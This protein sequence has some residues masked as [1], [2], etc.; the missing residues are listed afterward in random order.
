ME[1]W[2]KATA[3]CMLIESPN[4]RPAAASGDTTERNL[5]SSLCAKGSKVPT[6]EGT[7]VLVWALLRVL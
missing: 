5:P 7:K 3:C 2:K 4:A 6:L 1:A